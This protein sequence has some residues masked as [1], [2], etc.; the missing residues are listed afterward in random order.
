MTKIDLRESFRK[1]RDEA[2]QPPEAPPELKTEPADPK[3]PRVSRKVTFTVTCDDLE[4]GEPRSVVVTSKVPDGAGLDA[5]AREVARMSGGV[6]WPLKPAGEYQRALMLA[7]VLVQAVDLDD[8]AWERAREDIVFLGVLY[9]G[10]AEHQAAYFRRQRDP[11]TG[12]VDPRLSGLAR[13]PL[14]PG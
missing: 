10:L 6:A 2:L 11:A 8:W 13:S 12:E 5:I 3:A 4:T 9:G 14:A 1:R 7:T